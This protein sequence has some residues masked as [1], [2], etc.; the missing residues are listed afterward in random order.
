MDGKK[1]RSSSKKYNQKQLKIF[2]GRSFSEHPYSR[3]APESS[4]V[5][6]HK[7]SSSSS[8]SSSSGSYGSW[9]HNLQKLWMRM[10]KRFRREKRVYDCSNNHVIVP[11]N[12]YTY[13]QNFDDD[14]ALASVE[15]E[16]LC[17][18]FSARFAASSSRSIMFT[19]VQSVR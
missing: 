17:R 10:R 6:E 7:A 15:P 9:S 1:W 18:S 11:Y 2:L 16:N 13:S 14:G 4:P 3:F 8:S 19:R 5:P 12:I